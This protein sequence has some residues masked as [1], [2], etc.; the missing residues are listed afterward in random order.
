MSLS[1]PVQ[2]R[3]HMLSLS[4]SCRCVSQNLRALSFTASPNLSIWLKVLDTFYDSFYSR[5]TTL[6][7]SL[8]SFLKMREIG[9]QD[10]HSV[11]VCV[12]VCVFVYVSALFQLVK[13]LTDFHENWHE[14]F[15]I[16]GHSNAVYFHFQ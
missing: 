5:I 2:H 10:H 12:C 8:P 16:G 7:F 13:T 3:T 11:C 14:Y 15:S 6:N 9:L 4:Y 1:V